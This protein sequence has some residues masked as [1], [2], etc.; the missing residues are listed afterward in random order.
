MK[1]ANATEQARKAGP[2]NIDQEKRRAADQA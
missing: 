1:A 2:V